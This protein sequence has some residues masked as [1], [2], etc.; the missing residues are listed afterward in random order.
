MGTDNKMENVYIVGI[1]GGSASGK[2]HFIKAIRKYFAKNEVCIIS[3]DDYYRPAD[4]QH[5]DEQ[6]IINFDL[7]GAIDDKLFLADLIALSKGQSLVKQEYMFNQ[8]GIVGKTF[9]L[10]PAPV[11]VIEGLFILYFEKLRKLFDLTIFIDSREDI[12]LSR[13]LERDVNERGLERE[14]I[15]YQWHEHVYPAYRRY[16]LPYR[17]EADVIIT[18]NFSYEKGLELIMDHLGSVLKKRDVH[19][20]DK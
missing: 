19:Y 20:Q 17:D 10:E 12:K 9:T 8:P 14:V 15:L 11:I 5:I 6:G 16:L 1:A 7:P 4:E 2:T 3:Q 18:N 13:R